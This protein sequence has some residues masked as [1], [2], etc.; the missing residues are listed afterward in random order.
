[1]YNSVQSV[2]SYVN[3]IAQRVK[4]CH[5]SEHT[6]RKFS[7]DLINVLV[8]AVNVTNEPSK[9]TDCG[10]PDFLISKKDIPIGFI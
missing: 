2:A 5:T 7:E 6:F 9:V 10:K 8:P 1:M 3:K 4:A